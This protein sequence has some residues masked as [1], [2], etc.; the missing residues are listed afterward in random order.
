MGHEAWV[1]L[2]STVRAR[3]SRARTVLTKSH[4]GKL[5]YMTTG[6]GRTNPVLISPVHTTTHS[7]FVAVPPKVTRAAQSAE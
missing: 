7:T 2:L 1:M 5:Y 3:R 4:N 6:R